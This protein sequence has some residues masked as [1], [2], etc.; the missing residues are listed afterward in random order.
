MADSYIMELELIENNMDREAAD[1]F[2]C[3]STMHV[4]HTPILII[5][6]SDYIIKTLNVDFL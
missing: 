2:F 6:D 1:T 5:L 4:H 3:F